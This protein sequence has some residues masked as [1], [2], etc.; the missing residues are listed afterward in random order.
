[1]TMNGL[2][3]KALLITLNISRWAGRRKDDNAAQHVSEAAD[4]Q[5][6]AVNVTKSLINGATFREIGRLA[7]EIRNTH[8]A[9]TLPWDDSGRRLMPTARFDQYW[10]EMN[11][12]RERYSEAVST[13]TSEYWLLKE[14]ARDQLGTLYNERDYPSIEDLRAKFSI[15]VN[16]SEIPRSDDIRIAVSE[17][18][19]D[20]IREDLQAETADALNQAKGDLYKRALT[21][22]QRIA[23]T[24]EDPGKIF[25]DSL[26]G[27][28]RDL[29]EFLPDYNLFDDPALS[30]LQARLESLIVSPD[31]LRT[32]INQR[33]ATATAAA[34]V[35]QDVN[36]VLNRLDF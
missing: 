33:Q 8:Y 18:A 9:Q 10:E 4:A 34:R 35:A 13:F 30:H 2:R 11:R 7:N 26:I 15:R 5:R 1:M 31:T 16:A 22:A 23:E 6:T 20:R 25:R 36:D 21:V 12:Y 28:L 29:V 17:K 3:D 32:N 24:L 27:N 14:K 19:L